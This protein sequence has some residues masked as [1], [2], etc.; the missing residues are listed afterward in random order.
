MTFES[1]AMSRSRRQVERTITVGRTSYVSHVTVAGDDHSNSSPSKVFSVSWL[2]SNAPPP[3]PVRV[4]RRVSIVD[5]FCGCG[6][7]TLGVAEAARALECAATPVLAVDTNPACI[8][9]YRHNFGSACNAVVGSVTSLLDRPPGKRLS[10]SERALQRKYADVDIAIGG[11]PCQGHSDLNNHTRRKDPRNNL[12]LSMARL[13]EVCR[14]KSLIIENVPGVAHD[15]GQVVDAVCG[16]LDGLGYSVWSG[17]LAAE[18]YG[19]AQCRKRFFLT[20]TLTGAPVAQRLKALETDTPPPLSAVVRDLLSLDPHPS[21][22]FNTSA[23]HSATNKK[24]IA[25]LFK[26]RLYDLP[27]AQRP[28][29]HRMKPHSYV[30]VYGRMRWNSPTQTITTGF[31]ST[32]QGRFVHPLRQR[33]LTPHEACRV[34]YLPDFFVFPETRRRHL[35]EMIGNA[36]PPKLAYAVALS[37][38]A[39]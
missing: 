2:R 35:Q 5:L 13:A 12:Y 4:R 16:V 30:S 14:P 36:V 18:Q 39:E 32:G 25:Y 17:V 31:G 27:N 24:R 1:F 33:T 8:A 26:H 7:M 29:C 6:A 22:T 10:T 9:T 11:P 37:L 34:Q 21:D 23:N 19:V 3:Q 20:A 38:L 15:R 28:Y